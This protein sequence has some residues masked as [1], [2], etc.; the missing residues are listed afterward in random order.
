MRKSHALSAPPATVPGGRATT[1]EK[2]RTLQ[3]KLANLTGRLRRHSE[4]AREEG[5]RGS[6]GFTLIELMVVLLIIGILMAIA[7]PTYLSE[8]NNA[9]NTAAQATVRNALIAVK[10]NYAELNEYAIPASSTASSY[11][12]YMQGEEPALKWAGGGTAVDQ[13][14]AVSEARFDNDQSIVLSAWSP[15]GKCWSAADIETSSSSSSLAQGVWYNE[16]TPASGSG[17]SGAGCT[18]TAPTSATG[19]YSTWTNRQVT[20]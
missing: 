8:R 14:N 20:P 17:G 5:K 16:S 7:I 12:A 18:A 1:N 19:W 10:A 2:G 9:Q 6:K 4:E 11:A 3:E 13:I 15:N